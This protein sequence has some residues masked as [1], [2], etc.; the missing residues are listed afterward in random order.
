MKFSYPAVFYPWDEDEGEGY[1]VTVPDL[2][3]VTSQGDNLA[4]AILMGI[5]AASGWIRLS[6][7]DGDDI[8]SASKIEDVR[9]DPDIGEGFVNWIAL[10]IEAYAAKYD[11]PLPVHA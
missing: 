7:E 2:P 3:G 5:D 8:P 4:E 11:L 1:T 9:P 10:D 6:L